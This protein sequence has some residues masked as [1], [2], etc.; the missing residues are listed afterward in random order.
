M[1]AMRRSGKPKCLPRQVFQSVFD[2]VGIADGS[3]T[4]LEAVSSLSA[5][6]M[7]VN[8]FPKKE[9]GVKWRCVWLPHLPFCHRQSP[10]GHHH[11]VVS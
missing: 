1:L 2:A 3:G 5:Q 4:K 10:R 9:V 6:R 8:T 7:R 11:A